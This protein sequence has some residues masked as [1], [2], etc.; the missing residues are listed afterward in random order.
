MAMAIINEI[1]FNYDDIDIYFGI[2][3]Y[4]IMILY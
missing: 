4:N 3:F 1:R 2:K